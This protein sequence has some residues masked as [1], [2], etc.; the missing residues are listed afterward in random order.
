MKVP[1]VSLDQIPQAEREEA[2]ALLKQLGITVDSPKEKT[3]IPNP[4]YIK[5][6]AV[7][8]HCSSKT[9]KLFYMSYNN[10]AKALTS[11]EIYEIPNGAKVQEDSLAVAYCPKCPKCPT[12]KRLL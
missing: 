11:R 3:Y 6:E 8:L 7:C 10:D 1:T 5:Y 12:C 9:T 2:E 4:Y